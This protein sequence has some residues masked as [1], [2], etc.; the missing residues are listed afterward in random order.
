M[1][2]IKSTAIPASAESQTYD[3]NKKPPPFGHPIKHF[4]AFDPGYVN[5]NHG[6]YGSA[7]LPVLFECSKLTMQVEGNPD[8]FHRIGYIPM[9]EEARKRVADLIGAT[10]DEVVL[11]PNATH[12]INT[13]LRNI[14]W[15]E[16]D[17]LM[18]ASTTYGAISK[19]I[20]YLSDRSEQP[21]PTSHA[22][23]YTFPMTHAEI[24]DRFRARIRE[25]KQLHPDTDFSDAPSDSLPYVHGREKKNK[26]VAVIDSIVSNPGV[27]LPWKDMIQICKEEGIWSVVDAAHSIGQEM[28]IDIDVVR[29]DF[30]ISNCH[31]WLYVKRSCALLYVPQR[32]QYLI[33]SSVPT[34]HMYGAS[35][36]K[37]HE[38]TGTMDLAPFL[39]VSAALDFRNWLGGEAV[40]NTYCHQL[41]MDGGKR[42]AEVMGTKVM[43][44]TGELTLN[45][46]NVLL[47]LPVEGSTGQ[48][49]SYETLEAINTLFREKLLYE[50]NTYAAH[51]F[52]AGGWW[53]RCSAQV[54]NEISDFEYVGRAFN[55]IC[56]EIDETILSRKG[57]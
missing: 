6:S 20:E 17:V 45:M 4:W 7:P 1:T 36:V 29:P 31:K 56:K 54:W 9:L 41:A 48:V 46:T 57:G 50:W 18:G 8:K 32:N 44:E 16:G 3:V 49:Y 25:I 55:A 15:K 40:I 35:F 12:G 21:R 22:V 51:Y 2:A 19:T 26:F 28:N 47:P 30:F 38:W 24:L 37:Q 27:L 11:L 53:C 10:H 39:S 34:S 5:L 14:E 23:L 52:H 13:V 42:L 33:K 43:D